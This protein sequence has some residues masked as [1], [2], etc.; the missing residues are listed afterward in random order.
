MAGATQSDHSRSREEG[1]IPR[2]KSEFRLTRTKSPNTKMDRPLN[3][4]EAGA[5]CR[6]PSN[7][8]A[9]LDAASG[10]D[11]GS[12][13]HGS[14]SRLIDERI[15][16]L[17]A[18]VTPP[19]DQRIIT[20]QPAQPPDTSMVATL[21]QRGAAMVAADDLVAARLFYEHAV[22]LGSGQA[23]V[24]LAK[25]YDPCLHS[26]ER[27]QCWQKTGIGGRLQWA[28]PRPQTCRGSRPD[29]GV[30]L[31][32]TMLGIGMVAMP[33]AAENLPPIFF[34][35]EEREAPMFYYTMAAVG[36]MASASAAAVAQ[37]IP[38]P[39]PHPPGGISVTARSINGVPHTVTQTKTGPG[40]FV[41]ATASST[42]GGTASASAS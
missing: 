6:P 22:E 41:S 23:A 2:E 28:S 32:L 19:S 37:G 1:G 18:P 26:M 30:A 10:H 9:T 5:D 34:H 3:N 31:L 39:P 12:E 36:I 38:Q 24:E 35:N 42:P 15:A 8:V 33:A 4:I 11:A 16:A 21:M 27:T 13:R 20:A 7:P 25:S 17:G 40:T 29:E 14:R